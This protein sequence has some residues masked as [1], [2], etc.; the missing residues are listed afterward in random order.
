M[1]ASRHHNAWQA[2]NRRR[3]AELFAGLA[4]IEPAAFDAP[5]AELDPPARIDSLAR[6][7]GLASV[8]LMV[9]VLAAARDVEP[10]ALQGQQASYGAALA[11]F[12][13]EARLALCPQSAL[14]RWRMIELDGNGPLTERVLRID[15]RIL[16]HLL[17]IDYLDIRLDGLVAPLPE[18]VP[19]TGD[20]LGLHERVSHLWS[21]DT[22]TGWPCLQL[23]G[24]QTDALRALAAGLVTPHGQRVLRLDR[25]DIPHSAFERQAL[26]RLCD[27]EMALSQSVLLIDG[28][29][30]DND[31]RHAS[32]FI[33][34]LLGPVILA[35]RDGLALEQRRRIRI[36]MPPPT[37]DGQRANWEQ[38]L[39]SR[40]S[41]M[42]DGLDQLSEQ[43]ELDGD[44]IRAASA[45]ANDGSG[46]F[47]GSYFAR[48]WDAARG[49]ARR[50]LDGLAERIEGTANW[51]DLVLPPD[52]LAQLRDIEVHVRRASQVHRQWGW[53]DRGSRGLGVTA[54]FAGPSGTGKTMA[55]EVLANTLSLDLY[56]V[57]L[58]Q[59]VSKYIGETEKNLKSVFEAAEAG[60][61]ILL[62]DEAD[63]LFGKRSEVKDSH[64]RYA[65]VEVSY[66]LQRMEAYRGLAVLTTNLKGSLDTAFM[67]RLR[68]VIDFPFPDASLRTE[69]WER[70]FPAATPVAKLDTSRLAR[71][72][73]A[74][75]SIRTIAINA[76]FMAAEAGGSVSSEHV[77]AAARREYAKM[78][79]PVTSAEF[80]DAA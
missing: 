8:D 65:N 57:D 20:L 38:A 56:R 28:D 35:G 26:A 70:V 24:T 9:L 10:D 74:G 22:K 68:F 37:R 12:G 58:S 19:I 21:S 29:G 62:F 54:L 13:E 76:A 51:E 34:S 47:N 11:R 53:S 75:G 23:C 39:G 44:G 6:L 25:S 49:Q 27:R 80:G 3:L 55:A 45:L 7:F 18:Q 79:K 46:K 30:I 31:A 77:L 60:G 1:S 66:L 67:R 73:I 72:A 5:P 71:L 59:I 2:A 41:A 78:E 50:R 43:F 36:D 33:D 32:A 15:E 42:G 16:N 64:D 4:G 14:R 63:A 52:R 40:A 69:I 17:G 61:A 48:M